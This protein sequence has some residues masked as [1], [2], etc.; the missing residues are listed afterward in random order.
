MSA[1]LKEKYNALPEKSAYTSRRILIYPFLSGG[2]INCRNDIDFAVKKK[3][4]R[5]TWKFPFFP[6]ILINIFFYGQDR[7]KTEET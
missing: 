5:Q 1:V 3:K 7:K 4:G 6:D 2:C